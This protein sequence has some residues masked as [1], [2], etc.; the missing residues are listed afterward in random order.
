MGN[1]V[2]TQ[3]PLVFGG[4]FCFRGCS[5]STISNGRRGSGTPLSQEMRQHPQV[6]RNRSELFQLIFCLVLQNAEILPGSLLLDVSMASPQASPARRSTSQEMKYQ[7]C[8]LTHTRWT[9]VLSNF[10][11]VDSDIYLN[12][13]MLTI[14]QCQSVVSSMPYSCLI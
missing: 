8:S 14:L 12:E 9:K 13:V 3:L 7:F 10:H 4:K 1:N 6:S 2:Q 5:V 11:L